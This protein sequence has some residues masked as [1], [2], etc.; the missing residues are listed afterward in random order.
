MN[1]QHTSHH[2]LLCLPQLQT[3]KITIGIRI[4]TTLTDI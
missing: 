4:K 3:R 1:L 2:Q